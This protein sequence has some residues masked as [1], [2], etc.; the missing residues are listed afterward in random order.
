MMAFLS[1]D[2]ADVALKKYQTQFVKKSI[3]II[4][5]SQEATCIEGCVVFLF[6]ELIF[7]L[8]FLEDQGPELNIEHLLVS[9][10]M[11]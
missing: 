3:I 4:L 8:V 7:I 5:T 11:P 10:L 2:R 6:R 9:L 1:N